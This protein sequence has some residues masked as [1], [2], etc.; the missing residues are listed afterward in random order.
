MSESVYA[1]GRALARRLAAVFYDSLA[2]TGLLTVAAVPYIVIAG[3]RPWHWAVR[4]VFQG[5]LLAAAF[6]FFGWFWVHGG[7]TIGMRAWRVRVVSGLGAP[8]TWQQAAIRFAT[9]LLS[10]AALGLGF[11]WCLVDRE[12]LA[13]HDRL[14]G[15]K[16][17]VISKR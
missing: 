6:A 16:L 17:V 15:T 12:G 2:V 4:L 13:W 9:A 7:Q 1:R 10:W 11:L 5:Y 3:E 14:S 8:L